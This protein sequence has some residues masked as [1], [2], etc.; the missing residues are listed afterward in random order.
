MLGYDI[1]E[2]ARGIVR[3]T[4]PFVGMHG[5]VEIS[6][7]CE[8]NGR[9]ARRTVMAGEQREFGEISCR[10]MIVNSLGAK[11]IDFVR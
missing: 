1:G 5:P 8:P 10:T 9:A 2:M 11:A 4:E 6:V 7:A 3:E